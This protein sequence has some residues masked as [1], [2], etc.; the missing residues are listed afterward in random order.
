[1]A[2]DPAS[3]RIPPPLLT[4]RRRVQLKTTT[5]T[6]M[7]YLPASVQRILEGGIVSEGEG[8]GRGG[9]RRGDTDT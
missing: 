9:E 1:M 8:K 5:T 2:F 6:I 4:K 7:E 3:P